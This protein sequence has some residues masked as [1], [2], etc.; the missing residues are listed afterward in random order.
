VTRVL[1][2]AVVAVM[3]FLLIRSA[4]RSFMAGLSGRPGTPVARRDALVKDPQCETYIPRG[5]AIQ[6]TVD[7]ATHYFCSAGCADRFLARR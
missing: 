3:L 4:V 1:L 2:L 5:K 6:R 7:G